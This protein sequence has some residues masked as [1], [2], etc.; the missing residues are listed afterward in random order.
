MPEPIQGALSGA[1]SLKVTISGAEALRTLKQDLQEIAQ[2]AREISKTVGASM[3]SNL[4]AQTEFV[5]QIQ[6]QAQAL[7]LS[8]E[9]IKTLLDKQHLSILRNLEVTKQG[10]SAAQARAAVEAIVTEGIKGQAEA[11]NIVRNAYMMAAAQGRD[12]TEVLKEQLL[13]AGANQKQVEKF[14]AT[15]QKITS[16]R[17]VT[18]ITTLSQ[19]GQ[20]GGLLSVGGAFMGLIPGVPMGPVMAAQRMGFGIAL[21]RATGGWVAQRAWLIGLGSLIAG[22]VAAGISS[23]ISKFVQLEEA[24]VRIQLAAGK[25]AGSIG[26]ISAK[27]REVASSTGYAYSI[28]QVTE[29]VQALVKSG[30]SF[31]EAI[32][33][34]AQTA[35][36]F[37]RVAEVDVQTAAVQ[38]VTL[39][40]QFGRSFEQMGDII[41]RVADLTSSSL[42]YITTAFIESASAAQAFGVSV[43]DLS[44]IL[45]ILD[46]LG[47]RGP[48]AATAIRALMTALS[49]LKGGMLAQPQRAV[50]VRLGLTGALFEFQHDLISFVEFLERLKAAGPSTADLMALFTRRGE[51]A[52][53]AIM[54]MSDQFQSLSK[55]AADAKGALAEY[56]KRLE[57]TTAVIFN[58][59]LNRFGTF[60]TQVGEMLIQLLATIIEWMSGIFPEL[61][62]EIKLI[63]KRTEVMRRVMEG[64]SFS[65][66]LRELLTFFSKPARIPKE[67][68]FKHLRETL[69]EL[70]DLAFAADREGHFLAA[71]RAERR[72]ISEYIRELAPLAIPGEASPQ[73]RETFL[74][75]VEVAAALDSIITST[76]EKLRQDMP[77]V[78]EREQLTL[79]DAVRN[80]INALSLSISEGIHAAAIAERYGGIVDML[81]TIFDTF[82]Q[83]MAKAIRT[84][85]E[86]FLYSTDGEKLFKALGLDKLFPSDPGLIRS[87]ISTALANIFADLA[88][89][90]MGLFT[91]TGNAIVRVI[92]SGLTS[93]LG[94]LF[95]QY[96]G[97]RL[98]SPDWGAVRYTRTGQGIAPLGRIY[99]PTFA[100]TVHIGTIN[101]NGRAMGRDHDA[102]ASA[103]Y[104]QVQRAAL[105]AVEAATATMSITAEGM[106][107]F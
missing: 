1:I 17:D 77:K 58:T 92:T 42:Q 78:V 62:Y 46:R 18:N 28:E 39:S 98:R 40:S 61:S 100:P 32:G 3:K 55:Q 27:L 86:L 79:G 45:V 10:I 99:S 11:L 95:G 64:G 93:F 12:F 57:N 71:L 91:G 75:F 29:A 35:L 47:I 85:I 88:N 24:L 54:K 80:I 59:I 74:W 83:S 81:N 6:Q 4:Q 49:E 89:G 102:L 21:A 82:V 15:L 69:K 20:L 56:A 26:E 84:N 94:W 25:A 52:A 96:G 5:K 106:E 72:I 50:L 13:T 65:E 9:Q 41:T 23:S 44:A 8:G 107:D 68:A 22:T 103:I 76:M 30:L 2:M 7:G 38:L 67:E 36:R 34:A 66:A 16:R 31:K 51:R 73:N 70:Q 37:A 60:L 97:G 33:G 101:V 90:L 43:E 87:L 104:A 63:K 48:E 14:S 105:M 53:S 19:S